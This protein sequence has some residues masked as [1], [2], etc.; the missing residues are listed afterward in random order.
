MPKNYFDTFGER[1]PLE[2]TNTFF[3]RLNFD[4]Q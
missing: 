3:A 4:K 2:K 1:K